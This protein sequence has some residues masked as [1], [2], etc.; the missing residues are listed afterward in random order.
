MLINTE[1]IIVCTNTKLRTFLIVNIFSYINL[2]S[3]K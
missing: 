3:N 2:N 1:Y